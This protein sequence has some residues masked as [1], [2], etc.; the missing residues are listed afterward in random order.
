MPTMQDL[1]DAA[2]LR[3]N[4]AQRNLDATTQTLVTMRDQVEAGNQHITHEQITQAIKAR[5]TARDAFEAAE[6]H[7]EAMRAEKAEDDRVD[8][9]ARQ[10][11]PTGV[12]RSYNSQ[13]RIGDGPAIYA[14]HTERDGVSFVRDVVSATL[15]GDVTARE[16]LARSTAA[17]F[18][19]LGWS[20]RDGTTANY[21][22]VVVPAYLTEMVA[23]A[24]RAGRPLAD[25]CTAHPLPSTGM[26]VNLSRITTGASVASQATEFAGVSE[27]DIDDTL[28]TVN[29]R[30]LAGQQD[31]SR[32]ALE[33][34]T[35]VDALIIADLIGAY[36]SE[37]DRQILNGVTASAEHQGLHTLSGA[38][39]VTYT[40]ASPTAAALYPKLFDALQ[41]TQLAAF[42]GA[43]HLVMHPRRWWW[44]AAQ[45][46]TSQ[47][48]LQVAGVGTNQAGTVNAPNYAGAAGSLAGVPVILDAHIATNLGGGTEDA[49]YV[50]SANELHLWETPNAP[51]M[52][53]AEQP[54][55]GNL[56]VKLVA[57]GFSAFTA[58][59]YPAAH[60]VLSGT[61]LAAPSF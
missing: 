6:A 41:K 49:I 28:L 34:G 47:P 48:F 24:A 3:C 20:E 50:V 35:G 60:A 46:G 4:S 16:R 56:G 53:R 21:S 11:T 39:A 37:L 51:V 45:V 2:Q 31:V 38:S 22:G 26:T 52:I 27:T 8:A 40:D 15:H 23:P 17:E 59:R 1:I 5:E 44:L 30:T 7:L 18:N 58:G 19:R 12:K 55:A 43:S 9:L 36:H 54:A 57:Y 42:A 14:P 32:Q 25:L 13:V 33:R 10:I 61:G 29:V